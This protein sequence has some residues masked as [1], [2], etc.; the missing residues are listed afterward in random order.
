M[1]D[2]LRNSHKDQLRNSKN[3]QLPKGKLF[4]GIFVNGK[5][6]GY[7][8]L[9]DGHNS[10]FGNFKNDVPNGEGLIIKDMK[11]YIKGHFDNGKL[12]G[13]AK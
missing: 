5:M 2:S 9:Y 8:E 10:Y 3:N 13:E 1:I 6:N 11:D 7:G 4:R 12:K